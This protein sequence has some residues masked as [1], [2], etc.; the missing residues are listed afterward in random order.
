MTKHR[1]VDGQ[2]FEAFDQTSYGPQKRNVVWATTYQDVRWIVQRHRWCLPTTHWGW[3]ARFA[4]VTVYGDTLNDIV[5]EIEKA[6][7]KGRVKIG[8]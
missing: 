7:N 8:I 5:F 4:D 2:R 6:H 3:R 1:T